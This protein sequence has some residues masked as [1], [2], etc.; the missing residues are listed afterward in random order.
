ML[1]CLWHPYIIVCD[2]TRYTQ[3]VFSPVLRLP[4]ARAVGNVCP[5]LLA[6]EPNEQ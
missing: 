1:Y 4:D 6:A 3:V 5:A 2:S